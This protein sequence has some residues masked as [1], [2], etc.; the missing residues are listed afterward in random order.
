LERVQP[1]GFGL[2]QRRAKSWRFL[3]SLGVHRKGTVYILIHISFT[4]PI[5]HYSYHTE[6]YLWRVTDQCRQIIPFC[7]LLFDIFCII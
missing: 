3:L 4:C 6:L 1:F 5:L 7:M 2:A